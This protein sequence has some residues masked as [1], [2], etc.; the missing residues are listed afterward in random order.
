MLHRL[1]NELQV[2]VLEI[3]STVVRHLLLPM[4]WALLLSPQMD[5]KFQL[6]DYSQTHTRS[7]QFDWL[8]HIGQIS[9]CQNLLM[10]ALRTHSGL[11]KTENCQ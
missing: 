5:K 11:V 9:L 10:Q 8:S 4:E 3:F 1:R 2:S 6:M 7:I